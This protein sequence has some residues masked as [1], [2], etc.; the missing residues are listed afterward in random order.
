MIPSLLEVFAEFLLLTDPFKGLPAMNR[1]A[2][3]ILE[4][5][6]QTN[7]ALRLPLYYTRLGKPRPKPK[8]F[9]EAIQYGLGLLTAFAS[10]ADTNQIIVRLKDGERDAISMQ[11]RLFGANWVR[12]HGISPA[13]LW[14]NNTDPMP[15]PDPALPAEEQA[16][17]LSTRGMLHMAGKVA[18]AIQRMDPLTPADGTVT[19]VFNEEY[20][21]FARAVF[22][23][24]A[25]NQPQRQVALLRV[26]T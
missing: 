8:I 2:D 16:S 12:K 4:A 1:P 7:M 17:E 5:S 26:E 14:N 10:A 9:E 6:K 20:P 3:T 19:F 24:L 18:L 13:N 25:A 23:P 11:P 22:R 15:A 21:L